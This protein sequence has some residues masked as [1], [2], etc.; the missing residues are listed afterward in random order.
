[1]KTF[2]GPHSYSYHYADPLCAFMQNKVLARLCFLNNANF[3]PKSISEIHYLE[4][5]NTIGAPAEDAYNNYRHEKAKSDD[6]G[7]FD[8]AHWGCSGHG[9][10][11]SEIS[12]TIYQWMQEGQV[13]GADGQDMLGKYSRSFI[14]EF[15]TAYLN[16]EA[17]KFVAD[18]EARDLGRKTIAIKV[19]AAPPPAPTSIQQTK[20]INNSEA[21]VNPAGGIDNTVIMQYMECGQNPSRTG[22]QSGA[23][24]PAPGAPSVT[25]RGCPECAGRTTGACADQTTCGDD[26]LPCLVC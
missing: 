7:E 4:N 15:V 19:D 23:P 26:L 22:S 1:M 17:G 18:S 20:T 9:V 10:Q 3:T 11:N 16:Q 25:S 13:G 8:D 24:D 14:K 5:P 12:P 2:F 6:Y 21:I